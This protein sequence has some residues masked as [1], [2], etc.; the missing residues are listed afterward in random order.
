MARY[1]GRHR[2]V[3]TPLIKRPSVVLPTSGIAVATA[4]VAVTYHAD[5]A[6]GSTGQ[7]GSDLRVAAAPVPVAAPSPDASLAGSVAKARAARAAAQRAAGQRIAI[8]RAAAARAALAAKMTVGTDALP[9]KADEQAPPP[10][11]APSTPSALAARAAT[12]STSR[13]GATRSATGWVCPM[14]S[15]GATFASGFGGRVSPGGIGSTDHKGN[16]FPTPTGTPLR[17]M[18]AGTIV[19]AGWYGGQGKRVVIDFGG[20]VSAVYAHMSALNVSAGQRV[21]AGEV[22]GLSGN[23]GNST[24]PHLHIEIHIG[25]VPVNPQPWL[26]ARG[27]W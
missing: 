7:L 9:A 24:G 23:T 22:V 21:A 4:A 1:R 10:A 20:G 6:S 16:D 27:L 25:G 14:A 18:N 12:P 11:A 17:A 8:S 3:R 26:Q 15:C 13:S 19:A 2:P 5:I